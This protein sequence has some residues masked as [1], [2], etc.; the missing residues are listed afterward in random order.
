[1]MRALCFTVDLDRDVNTPIQGSSAAGSLDF[2]NGTGPR[3]TSTEKGLHLLME[4]LDELGIKATFFA[5]A[6]TLKM[7]GADLSKHDLGIHGVD[8][9]D[10]S[11]IED[12]EKK[13]SILKEA[14]ETVKEAAGRRP[15]C[16]RAPYMKA[17]NETIGMLPEFGISVDS[18]RYTKMSSSLVPKRMECGVWEMPVPEGTD[19]NG[20]KIAAYLWPMHEQKREPSD[21]IRLASS[22]K[23]GAFVIATHTWHIVESRQKGIMTKAEI[24]RN[25]SNVREVLEGIADLDLVPKTLTDVRRAMECSL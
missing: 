2:G 5:E 24:E 21:Y 12:P 7:I 15:E 3:F 4:L 10:L 1:M 14:C 8:H 25:I 9:E 23:E 18:S 6:T 19:A 16:F 20:K 11:L 22:M 13:R 17:D